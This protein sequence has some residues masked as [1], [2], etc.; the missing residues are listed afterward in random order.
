[1][2]DTLRVSPSLK[3][4][5]S[6]L[7]PMLLCVG[8]LRHVAYIPIARA[9]AFS[10]RSGVVGCRPGPSVTLW[11]S[12][13]R[14]ILLSVGHGHRSRAGPAHRV[15]MVLSVSNFP[16]SHSATSITSTTPSPPGRSPSPFDGSDASSLDEI[17]RASCLP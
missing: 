6:H 12:H 7:G 10:P 11:L 5:L 16:T 14:P 4:W 8:Y 17:H 2:C 13:L 9:L 15:P 1:M 3:L